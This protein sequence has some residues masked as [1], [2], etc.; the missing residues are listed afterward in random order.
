MDE[1]HFIKD[2]VAFS[3][4]SQ[5]FFHYKTILLSVKKSDSKGLK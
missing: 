5:H 1:L 2:T 3:F 4:F